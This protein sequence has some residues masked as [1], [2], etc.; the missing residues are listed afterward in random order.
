[1]AS[2]DGLV[3]GLNTAQIISSLMQ[4]EPLPG[5]PV[6]SGYLDSELGHH[7]ELASDPLD[8]GTERHACELPR[9]DVPGR[10][11]PQEPTRIRLSHL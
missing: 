8:D 3:S 5:D 6:G 4:V 7:S 2:V 9:G 1:M 10:E 11:L